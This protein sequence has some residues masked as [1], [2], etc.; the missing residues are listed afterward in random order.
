MEHGIPIERLAHLLATGPAR[1]FGYGR[2][3]GRLSV[4]C[5]GDVVVWDPTG[6]WTVEAGSFPDGTD[7][8]PYLGRRV[9]GRVQ[10]VALRGRPLVRDGALAE[11][12]TAGRLLTPRGMKDHEDG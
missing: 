10:F 2:R 5:D 3:K 1:A 6:D 9:R 7:T 4:G 12:L 8:S 11:P